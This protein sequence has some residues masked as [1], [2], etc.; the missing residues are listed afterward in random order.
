MKL[1]IMQ[2]YFFPYLGY[3]DLLNSV[4]LLIVSDLTQ[5]VKESWM[6]RN[7]ILHPNKSTWQ[8][9]TVPVDKASFRNSYRTPILEIKV[10]RDKKW[11]QHMI[12]QLSHYNKIA[13]GADSTIDFVRKCLEIEE[14]FLA[15]LNVHILAQCAKLLK[16][17]FRYRLMSELGIEL[18]L[19]RSA[20]ERILDVCKFLGAT[21]YVNLP[22]GK[23]L[24]HQ[25]VF[26]IHNIK[27]TF[28]NLPSLMYSTGSYI[29]EPNLSIVDVLMW[30]TA[31]TVKNYL[32]QQLDK[33]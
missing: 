32:D 6:N 4:D 31:E 20:E 22:G 26:A 23:G 25:D 8:Y 16:I 1:G 28:R 21:E 7:R 17:D 5:Y 15:R 24:Y 33:G 27:L 18:N 2:P 9:I 13:P 12:G 10:V 11:K 14:D 29:F 3:F 30:N 19:E